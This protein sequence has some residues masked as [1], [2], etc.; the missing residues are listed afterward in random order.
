ML[1]TLLVVPP[2]FQTFLRPCLQRLNHIRNGEIDSFR[3]YTGWQI[4]IKIDIEKMYLEIWPPLLEICAESV[5]K[6]ISHWR[7]CH[8]HMPN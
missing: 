1:T 3:I 8:G 5:S 6:P 7:K 4:V 2:D